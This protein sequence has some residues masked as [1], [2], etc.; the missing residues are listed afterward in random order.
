[1]S[2]RVVH[3]CASTDIAESGRGVR[4][5]VRSG[6]ASETGFVI[7]YRGVV[8]GYLNRCAHVP[9]ELDWTPGVLFDTTGSYLICATHGALYDPQTGQ[10]VAGPCAGRRL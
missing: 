3:I 2:H 7:R 10:C 5:P 9:I 6:H 8:Y 1:M 4:F